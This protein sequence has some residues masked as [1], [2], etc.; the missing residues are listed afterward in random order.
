MLSKYKIL[1]LACPTRRNT[2]A[3]LAPAFHP[4]RPWRLLFKPQLQAQDRGLF[5]KSLP[6]PPL[7]GAKQTLHLGQVNSRRPTRPRPDLQQTGAGVLDVLK[8]D[9]LGWCEA[10]GQAGAGCQENTAQRTQSAPRRKK[11]ETRG[12]LDPFLPKD[13]L[14]PH[15]GSCSG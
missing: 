6:H 4:L 7:M 3:S 13:A 11:E 15:S 14:R 10:L 2:A 8:A 12:S 9:E 1:C 5:C